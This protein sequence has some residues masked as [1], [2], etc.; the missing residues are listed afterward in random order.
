MENDEFILP[1][2]T[3]KEIGLATLKTIESLKGVSLFKAFIYFFVYSISFSQAES[4]IEALDIW[5]EEKLKL[6]E[7]EA[8]QKA[9]GKEVMQ[10]V[11]FIKE[12]KKMLFVN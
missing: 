4:I 10:L 8:T 6:A 3:N 12:N 5:R 7:H 1:G 11:L 9:L 2:E